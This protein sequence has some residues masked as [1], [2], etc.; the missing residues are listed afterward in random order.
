MRRAALIPVLAAI[1]FGVAGCG[2][3]E[4]VSPAPETV[5][6]TLPAATTTA[7][8][9][10]LKG[11]ATAGKSVFAS[12]GCASCH[13]LKAAGATGTVGPN[14]DETKP[15]VDR[16]VDRVTNGRGVMPPFK[17]TLKEQQIADVAAYVSENAGG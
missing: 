6:G 13:T 4:T 2:G 11:D 12:S 7:P 5:V 17:G 16:I 14:L 8:T 9:T 10:G 15:A 1:A 3:A